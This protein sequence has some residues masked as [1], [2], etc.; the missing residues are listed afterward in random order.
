[1][2]AQIALPWLTIAA[3]AT[4]TEESL[5]RRRRGHWLRV[6]RQRAG[7]TLKEVAHAMEYS[8]WSQTTIKKWEDGERDP[9]DVQLRR[10][11]GV[12]GVPVEVFTD[13]D[14]TDEER[15]EAKIRRVIGERNRRNDAQ[16]A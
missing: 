15:L 9:S 13:P 10:L 7:L 4:P 16:T 11:A 2:S 14:E 8:Q 6:A 3:V 5:Y 1:L 12:L